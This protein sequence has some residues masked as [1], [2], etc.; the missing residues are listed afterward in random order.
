MI[1]HHGKHVVFDMVIHLPVEIAEDRVQ[2]DRP[3]IE[4]VIQDVFRQSGMLGEPEDH[5]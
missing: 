3:T 2:V 1:R 5:H 4:P